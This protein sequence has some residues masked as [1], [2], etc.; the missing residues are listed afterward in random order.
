MAAKLAAAILVVLA[1]AGAASAAH[2]ARSVSCAGFVVSYSDASA[3]YT[4][5]VSRLRATGTTCATARRVA[6]AVATAL[7]HGR[8]PAKVIGGFAIH[9][10]E[11]CAG[12]PPVYKVK[13][14]GT[15]AVRCPVGSSAAGSSACVAVITFT[16]RGG[17]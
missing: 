11:P 17:V 2:G 9:I 6:R 15:T 16:G 3:T 14:T 4:F 12:C 13:A 8:T 7:L 5:G 10:T 1:L